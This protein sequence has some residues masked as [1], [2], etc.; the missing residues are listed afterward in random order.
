MTDKHL[1]LRILRLF[2]Q[3]FRLITVGLKKEIDE[4][5][6]EMEET[7]EQPGIAPSDLD[8]WLEERSERRRRLLPKLNKQA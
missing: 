2:L 5:E 3:G 4:L 1:I 6:K 7:R 8:R